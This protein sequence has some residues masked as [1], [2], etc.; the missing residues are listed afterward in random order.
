[1]RKK[2]ENEDLSEQNRP[3]RM[4]WVMISFAFVA[5][6]LNYLH[7]LS[8]NYLTTKGLL[9]P[10]LPEDVFGFIV[11]VFFIAYMFSKAFSGFVIDKL[12]PELAI[13]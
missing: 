13:H 3:L 9:H 5:T 10:M 11:S 6:V 2:L 8:F 7:S 12:A 4:F 1:M